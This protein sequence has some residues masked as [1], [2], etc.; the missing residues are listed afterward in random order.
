MYCQGQ[1][2]T[3]RGQSVT[4]DRVLLPGARVLQVTG[5]RVLLPGDRVL[6]RTECYCQGAEC[7]WLGSLYNVYQLICGSTIDL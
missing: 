4:G 3:A 7:Y 5:D 2:V 6:Q 1:S